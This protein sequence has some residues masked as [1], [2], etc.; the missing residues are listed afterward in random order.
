MKSASRYLR[1]GIY[2]YDAGQRVGGSAVAGR[3]ERGIT[4]S[5][6]YRNVWRV[7]RR[8]RTQSMSENHVYPL[9]RVPIIDPTVLPRMV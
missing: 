4:V 3:R 7:D 1:V 8:L 5:S 6:F 9:E 2:F